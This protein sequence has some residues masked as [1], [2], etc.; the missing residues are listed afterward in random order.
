MSDDFG[1]Y[2][3]PQSKFEWRPE[4]VTILTDEEAAAADAEYQEWL[5]ACNEEVE[6]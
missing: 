6:G 4:D 3:H 2:I 5:S 1:E